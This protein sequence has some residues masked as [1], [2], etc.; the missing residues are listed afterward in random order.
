MLELLQ[1]YQSLAYL[2]HTIIS[3]P[4]NVPRFFFSNGET[5]PSGPGP[6]HYRG[7]TITLS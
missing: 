2:R 4:G 5:A 1:P 7:F 3:V 6:P